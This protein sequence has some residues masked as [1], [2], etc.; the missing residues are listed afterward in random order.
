[1]HADLQIECLGLNEA[2][3]SLHAAIRK[4]FTSHP[5]NMVTKPDSQH[6]TERKQLNQL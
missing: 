1:M 4:L 3:H 6:S 2:N 5:L